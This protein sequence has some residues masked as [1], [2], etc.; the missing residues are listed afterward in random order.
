MEAITKEILNEK[1][2]TY[3]DTHYIQRLQ[4]LMDKRRIELDD[5]ITTART[6]DR[7]DFEQ[8]YFMVRLQKECEYVIMFMCGHYIQVLGTPPSEAYYYNTLYDG[9]EVEITDRDFEKVVSQLYNLRVDDVIN[10]WKKDY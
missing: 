4:R 6:I 1:G 3:P 5:F 8:E 10:L 7:K 2:K 9:I